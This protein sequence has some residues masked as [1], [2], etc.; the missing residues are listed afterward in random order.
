MRACVP[1]DIQGRFRSQKSGTTQNVLAAI[2][3][4]LRFTNILA[5][6]EGSAHD[7]RVLD[8]A[9]SRPRGF[10]IPEGK[11]YLGDAEELSPPT[12]V[13]Y[14]LLLLSFPFD[15]MTMKTVVQV[16]NIFLLC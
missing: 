9:L 3:F 7:S 10:E 4:D 8:D 14:F 13:Q 1:V 12:G 15:G 11:F 5:G 16:L 6:W 2:T